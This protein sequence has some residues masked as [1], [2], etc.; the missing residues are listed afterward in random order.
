[1]LPASLGSTGESESDL[2]HPQVTLHIWLSAQL[3]YTIPL[4]LLRFVQVGGSFYGMRTRRAYP[5]SPE[6]MAS[7]S[8]SLSLS[9]SV[10]L[11]YLMVCSHRRWPPGTYLL[12]STTVRGRV[13][14]C[15]SESRSRDG[16]P[17]PTR[18]RIVLKHALPIC[19]PKLSTSSLFGGDGE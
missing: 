10:Y 5:R 2:S 17:G 3:Q 12:T 13:S 7:A 9:L 6:A 19:P 16:R 11:P 8:L 15:E 4:R 14:T 1:V 18:G